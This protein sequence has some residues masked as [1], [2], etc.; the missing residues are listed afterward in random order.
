MLIVGLVLRLGSK[1]MKKIAGIA[2]CFVMPFV[3]F[4]SC[5]F[6]A[7]NKP[8]KLYELYNSTSTPENHKLILR[9]FIDKKERFEK[10]TAARKHALSV[11]TAVRTAGVSSAAPVEADPGFSLGEVY[12][13]PN[14]AKKT[15]PTFHI[16]TGLADRVEL[17][18]YDVSGDIV[19]ETVLTGQPQVIDD[20]QGPQYAYEYL[21]DVRNVGSGVYIFSMTSWRGDKTLKKTG[22]CA[23]IK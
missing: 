18:F 4:F 23:V 20:G 15:N 14:P 6:A 10:M 11:P 16:E 9:H 12:C 3:V 17:K 13:Y 1:H 5:S 22:R 2:V 8:N 21:W 19:H 7:G